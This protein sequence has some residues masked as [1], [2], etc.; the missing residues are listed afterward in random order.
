[1]SVDLLAAP[2]AH[3]MSWTSTTA[4]NRSAQA[5]TAL[6]SVDSTGPALNSVTLSGL[7]GQTFANGSTLYYNAQGA[8]S[9][10][11]TV[12]SSF[13]DADSGV[14]TV[15]YPAVAGMTGGSGTATNASPSTSAY[16][17]SSPTAYSWTSATT[18]T[19]AQ[20]VT[21]TNRQGG[22]GTGTF[23][24]VKDTTAPA[25]GALSVNSTAASGAGTSSWL[26]TG[27]TVTVNTR[28]DYT[29]AQSGTASGLATSTL[30]RDQSTLSNGSCGGTWTNATT[31]ATISGGTD[32]GLVSGTCYRYTLTGTD[33]V[34]NAASISTIVK[35]DTSAPTHSVSLNSPTNAY[36]NG[37]TLYYRNSVAGSFTFSDALADP[38]SGPASVT[39]PAL[40][41]YTGQTVATGPNYT[42]T[43][44]S[45]NAAAANP[46]TYTITGTNN[47]AKT[48]TQ[49][50]TVTLDN[51]A[52][53]TGSISVP[54]FSSTLG[55]IVIT[56]T[57][58]TDA[59]SG[60]A[61]NV[62]TRSN[63]QA[64]SSPGVCPAA[65]YSGSTVV[66]SPDTVPTD[67]QCYLYTLTGT[68][69]VNNTASV[70]SAPI[71][72]DTTVPSTPTV[73]FTGLSAGNTYDNGSGTLFFRPSAGGTFTVNAASTDA[74]S[75]I[76]TGNAGY[77]FGTL[78]S[79]GGTNFGTAQAAGALSV[80]FTGTT[81]GPTTARTVNSTNGSGLNSATANYNV[82]QDSTAPSGGAVSVPAFSS[83]L[84]SI[85]ITT[86]NYTDAGSGIASNV[87]TRSN[88]Q[89]PSSPGVCPASGY[90]GSTVVTSPD[91][92]PT[93]GR[94]YLY[95]LTGTD[96]VNN[97]A[98]VSSAPILVD[99]TVPSTPTVTF[100]GLSAGNTYDNGSGTL[101]F[102]PSAGGTF[103][104]NAASTD[105]QSGI[106]AGNAGYTFGT[107]NSNGGSNFGTAQASGALSVTFTGTT[108]GPTTARTVNSTNGSGLNSATANYNVTQDSAAPSGGAVSVPAFSSTL[109]SIVI[110]KTNYT[111]AGSG[112]ASNV[113]TRSNAQAPSSPGVCPASGYSGSTVVTSPD[114]VPTDGQCYVYTLTGTDNVGNT[115][116]VS[117]SP[118]LVDTTTPSTPTVTFSGLSAGNTYDNGSGTLFFRP[119]A[120]GTFTV[121]AASTDA[122]SGIQAG[123]AGYTFGT[124]NS[125]G[126]SNFGTAQASGALSVTFTGATTGPTTQRTVT[127]TN[128]SGLNSAAANYTI[129]QDST[130]PTGGAVSV[131]AFSST[132]GSIVITTT[133]YTDAGSGIA[134][135]V[136]TRSNAQAPSS[137][138]VCPASGYSGSTVVSSPDTVP[139]DGQC[140][141]Y[142]LT[143]TDR[144]G[145]SAAV[146]SAPILV[147]T[148]VPSTPNVTF[149]GLSAGNTYDN[150]SGTLFFRPSAGGTFT[151]NA[152]SS[153]AQ[154]GIQAGNAGYTFGTLNSNGGSNFGTA[155]AS[156]A[157][158]VT[159]TG[160]TTGPTTARTVNSS[161]GSGLNSA[162][163]NYTVTQDS[164]APS[165]GIVSVPAFSSTLGSIV[166]T[167]TN[168]TDA[169]SGIASNVI[170]RSNAQAP[171]SPGVCPASGYS[172]S[173]V[174]TSPDTVPTDGQC[175]LY[176]LTGTDHV[177]NTASVSSSPILV[178]T[179]VPSTP[180]VTFSGLSAGNTYDNGSGTLFFRPSVG[181]TFTVNASSS[182]AQSGIQAGNAGYTFGSLNSNGGS[183]FGTAQASGALSV[184]FT[185]TTTGPTTARTVNSSNGSGLN[186]ATANYTITQDSTAPSG[187]IVSV[188]AFSST[189]GSI[190]ITTTNYTDAG[191]GIASNV[192]TRS[193]AQAPSARASAPPAATAARPSSPAP[194]P[195]PPTASATCTR[196][197]APTTSATPRA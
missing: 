55:S 160:A 91:T 169:G 122:Q 189:L 150:G 2:G 162:A 19:G 167:T 155:Q 34:A 156:G 142:T 46:G 107:L 161:N 145:N 25:G 12:N 197:P 96:H 82:T 93:D 97:T 71:L 191:S 193:N 110:T 89:A 21:A 137:P 147:D 139:T 13:T 70:S 20:T 188:P 105:A 31:L 132:L 7:T 61:S 187:G 153:D 130:A 73:T 121:N 33:N 24:L 146:S 177:G 119:S 8:N 196:S 43:S 53:T 149:S 59:G 30:V 92:V 117:S 49:V 14:S 111:D 118:I 40:W 101:F 38:E 114:T 102:R 183:N 100:S 51:G 47:A 50:L 144:V 45:W 128:G 113:I 129:T 151:V 79:N 67:G 106:Q 16:A 138:G 131:P 57:N 83:T 165:G 175:Y 10:T 184:T 32:T 9:G 194:T 163:G 125:N 35:V 124:L 1:M 69:H 126:G 29:E 115:A 37:S 75:G 116:S 148:T 172:G 81:T 170:T 54:A 174:V 94:C 181:G 27:T 104:V 135:N 98:S 3:T 36:L 186:S 22:T 86:T 166:I 28:T 103:T 134:S 176:T 84:G 63:P 88:A 164:T 6:E 140:Y 171:S 157:L 78:N 74:Q 18:T 41:N 52:P 180:T 127:S 48:S 179:T 95:T 58:Y 99:T 173:T 76:Q 108:T 80:T 182:D 152:S 23:T 5:V 64:P 192:I 11:F 190:V 178:D 159:F 56:T 195:C 62:I 158:S 65:G 77:T 185:G 168:Y 44:V 66:T 133:N 87:I 123:N 136:I 26:N 15:A 109:G 72:V 85:V 120:G 112:I 17:S 39:Y 154:S 141:V 42:T 68:D 60:I 90:S 143:G 4:P